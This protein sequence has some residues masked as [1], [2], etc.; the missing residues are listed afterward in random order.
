MDVFE[1]RIYAQNCQLLGKIMINPSNGIF[2]TIFSDELLDPKRRV[3]ISNLFKG[4]GLFLK[5]LAKESSIYHQS[6]AKKTQKLP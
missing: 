1:N 4:K 5:F 3:P 6:L 2:G